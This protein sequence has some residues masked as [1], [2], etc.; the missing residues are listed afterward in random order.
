MPSHVG[1]A[2]KSAVP[3]GSCVLP[4]CRFAASAAPW[5]AVLRMFKEAKAL[6]E[7]QSCRQR[8]AAIILEVATRR[9]Q[10][11]GVDD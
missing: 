2:S 11:V 6:L 8:K 10:P 4:L 7:L 5:D 1:F 3:R 9:A